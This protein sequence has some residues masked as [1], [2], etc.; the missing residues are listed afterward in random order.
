MKLIPVRLNLA[1][2][3]PVLA[4][5]FLL[6]ATHPDSAPDTSAATV[7]KQRSVDAAQSAVATINAFH[8]A[9]EQG[10]TKAALMLLSEDVIIFES[11]GVESN[12]AEYAA[13]HL[14][15]DAEFSAATTRTG[16]SQVIKE[17]GHMAT[18]MRVD[19]V[20]GTFRGRPVNSRTVETMVLRQSDGLWR[21]VHIHW[22]STNLKS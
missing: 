22:S 7:V 2:F 10:E 16:V 3:A 15:A 20:K 13:H 4:A 5:L 11:G 21:I 19:L 8:A 12:R 9:L 6:A 14:T 17:D 18:I 1:A